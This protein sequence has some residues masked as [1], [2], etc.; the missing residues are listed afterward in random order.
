VDHRQEVVKAGKDNLTTNYIVQLDW[1]DSVKQTLAA[2]NAELMAFRLKIQDA[3]RK[4]V[5]HADCERV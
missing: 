5:A 2:K 1:P 3:R 4:L